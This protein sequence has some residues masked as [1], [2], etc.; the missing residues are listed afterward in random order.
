MSLTYTEEVITPAVAREILERSKGHIQLPIQRMVRRIAQSMS[1]GTWVNGIHPIMLS[2]DGILL[3][4]THRLHAIIASGICIPMT[5]VKGADQKTW[6]NIVRSKAP[7]A[8]N[9]AP[10]SESP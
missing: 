6:R 10:A 8:T 5:V 7:P 4:G 2:A 1:D 9:Q 3:D